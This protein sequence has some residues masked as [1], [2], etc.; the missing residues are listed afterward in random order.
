MK[1]YLELAQRVLDEGVTESNRTGIDTIRT[2][3]AQMRFDLSDNKI[4]AVTT[5][6]LHHKSI[7]HELVWMWHGM[8]N[9]QYLND[10][11]VRIWDEWA[12][13]NGDLGQVY[14][15]Q[16]RRWPVLERMGLGYMQTYVDQLKTVIETLK[17]NPTDR[18]MIVNSWNVGQLDKMALPP[19]HLMFQL[20][21]QPNPSGEGK[22][23]LKLQIYQRSVDV[24]LGLPF[25]LEFYSVLAHLIAHLTDH[26]A[27]ELIHVSG[28][29]HIY[30]NHVKQIEKQLTRKPK[31]CTPRVFISD[32]VT[33]MDDVA[34]EHFTIDGYKSHGKLTGKVAV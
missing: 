18:R 27:V 10:N 26:E 28:D 20:F 30:S 5:K 19:C 4:A 32:E 16:W 14:G 31:D 1:Q 22:R 34:Y 2:F 3:G 6:Q 17:T 7:L 21:S 12:D 29:A 8:T 23:Q 11:G 9:I 15:A 33:C 13:E 24:F 25:N